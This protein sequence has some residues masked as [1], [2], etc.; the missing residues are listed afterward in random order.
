MGGRIASQV[1]AAG[2]GD[3]AGTGLSRL[4]VPIARQT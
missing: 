3:L 2:A 4:P 1:A